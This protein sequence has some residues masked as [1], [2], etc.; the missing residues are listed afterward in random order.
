MYAALECLHAAYRAR[1]PRRRPMRAELDHV[2]LS[3]RAPLLLARFYVDV[4]QLEPKN[5]DEFAAGKVAFPSVRLNDAT[6]I[7]FQQAPKGETVE[8]PGHF[9]MCL[10]KRDFDA[11]ERR[12]Q[13]RG[14]EI[15]RPEEMLSG[16]RGDAWGLYIRDPEGN[17]VEF[18]WYP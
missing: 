14:V 9:C 15:E 4:L 1:H 2:A 17:M 5:V 8:R 12:L 7:D 13:A 6:I 11:L 18:R 16:A 3:A 10:R